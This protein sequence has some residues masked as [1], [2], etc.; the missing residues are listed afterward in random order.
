MS[1]VRKNASNQVI[2]VDP[3]KAFVLIEKEEDKDSRFVT[4]STLPRVEEGN[5]G[6]DEDD[7]EKEEEEEEEKEEDEEGK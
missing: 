3:L 1:Q 7:E 5:K 2:L 4:G 6:E